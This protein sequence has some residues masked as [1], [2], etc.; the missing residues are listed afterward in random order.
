[1]RD[2]GQILVGEKIKDL[3]VVNVEAEIKKHKLRIK[4]IKITMKIR[5]VKRKRRK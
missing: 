1:M 2:N 3:G 4:N 5:R